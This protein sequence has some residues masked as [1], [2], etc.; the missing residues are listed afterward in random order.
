[1]RRAHAPTDYQGN[2]SQRTDHHM[3][4]EENDQMVDHLS[5]KVQ[6]LKSLTIDIGNEVKYQNKMLNEMDTDFDSGGSLLSSTM[7]R[8]TALTK[9]GHHKVMLYLIVFCLFVFF[10]S[11]YIIKRR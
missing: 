1:M 4:E 8:L 3:L 6:A 5:S 9:K 10:V 2:M 11:W 7:G